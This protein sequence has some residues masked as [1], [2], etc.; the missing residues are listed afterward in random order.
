MAGS[1]WFAR[2]ARSPEPDPI[3]LAE[4]IRRGDLAAV[5]RYLDS[6]GSPDAE[7]EIYGQRM[8][9][10]KEAIYD[11]ETAIALLLIESGADLAT[12]GA[13]LSDVGANGM[14]ELVDLLLPRAD[15][16]NF[17]LTGI[18]RAAGHGYYDTVQS[19]IRFTEGRRTDDISRALQG[20]AGS[21]VLG[22]YDDVARALFD[23]GGLPPAILHGIARFSSPGMVRYLLARGCDPTEIW[24]PDVTGVEERTP[25]DFAWMSY[26]DRMLM[27]QESGADDNEY[28]RGRDAEYIFFELLRAGAQTDN[29]ELLA[30]A[31]DG[32]AEIG[33]APPDTQLTLA[34]HIGFIDVV[35]ELL[36]REAGWSDQILR[37]AVIAALLSD[38]DDVARLLLE[39][40]APVDGG[41][42]HAAANASSAGLVRYLLR[43]GASPTERVDGRTPVEAWLENNSAQDPHYVL[44]ELIVGGADVCW[45]R[46]RELRGFEASFFRNSAPECWDGDS[47]D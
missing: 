25:L 31:R 9:V 7:V 10:L 38:H 12:S 33:A 32:L 20:A 18:S 26:K 27:S 45:L 6:G 46:E 13:T 15:T 3:P 22:G 16:D 23:A 17:L 28:L 2:W 36:E 5:R 43:N 29:A 30:V 44:H 8:T 19:Y 41:V 37:E 40:G 14:T 47:N 11:R 35:A 39:S 4:S 34:A 21:A 42:L 1:L 24:E